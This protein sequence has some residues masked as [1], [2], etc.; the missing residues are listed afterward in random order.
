MSFLKQRD[1]QVEYLGE[2]TDITVDID[3]F[4]A[5][6][7]MKLFLLEHGVALD[8][9]GSV[10]GQDDMTCDGGCGCRCNEGEGE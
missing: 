8:E 2:V 1:I 7:S 6:A 9:D 5:G 10:P 3:Q 4:V